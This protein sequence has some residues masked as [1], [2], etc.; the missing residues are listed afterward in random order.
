M[1]PRMCCARRVVPLSLVLLALASLATLSSP[2]PAHAQY[3][4][5]NKVHYKDFKWEIIKTQHFEV[6]FYPKERQAALDA[7]RMAERSYARLSKVLGYEMTRPIPLVLYASHTDFQQTNISSDLISEGTGGVTEFLKRRVFLPFTGSYSELEHVLTH[8]LVHAFQV[9]ILFGPSG[10]ILSNPV[11]FQPP[12]WFMEGMAEYLSIGETDVHTKMWLRDGALQGYLTP[13]PVLGQVYDIRVYRFGQ[14][15]F[16][17]IGETFGEEKIGE[18][19]KT[20]ARLNSVNSAF[21]SVLGMP[22]EELSDAWLEEVRKEYLP[23]IASFEKPSKFARRLTWQDDDLSNLNLVPALSP[24]GEHVCFISD[25]SMYSD[26][27]LADATTG[28]VQKRLVKGERTGNFESLRFFNTSISWSADGKFLAFPAKIGGE[29]AIY[30]LE[31]EN[32][33][34]RRRLTFGLDGIVSPSFSPDGSEIVF[35]GIDGGRSDLY[36]TDIDGKNLRQLTEDRYTDRDPQFSPDGRTIAF[37]TD[38]GVGTNFEELVFGDYGLALYEIASGAITMLPNQEGKNIAPQWSPDGGELLFVSDRTGI[39]NMY[40][41]DLRTGDVYKLTNILTGITGIIA[42]AAPISLS[43]DGSR[44]VFSA[45]DHSGWD[46]YSI[47]DPFSLKQEPVRREQVISPVVVEDEEIAPVASLAAAPLLTGSNGS[48]ES[49]MRADV[50]SAMFATAPP[51]STPATLPAASAGESAASTDSAAA[52]PALVLA[53][54]IAAPGSR[55]IDIANLYPEADRPTPA[56]TGEVV[57]SEFSLPDT[58]SFETSRYKIRFTQDYLAGGA[59]FASNVGFAGQTALAFSD[60]LGNHSIFVAANIYGSITD[61]EVLLAYANLQKRLNWRVALF[62]YH[63]DYYVF[64]SDITT[65][66]QSQIYRGGEASFSY[67]FSK[68]RRVEFGLEGVSVSSNLYG[69]FVYPGNDRPDPTFSENLLY[70]RPSLALVH[71][72]VLYGSTGPIHGSRSRYS[73]DQAIGDL[74]FTTGVADFRKYFNFRHRYTFAVRLLGG[75]SDGR[76]P[77]VFRLGG[78]YTFRGADYGA[79]PGTRIALSNLEFRFPLIDRLQLGFPPLDFRGIGGILFFDMASA[80]RGRDFRFFE[81]APNGHWRL[82]DVL[83]AYGFGARVNLGYFILR[84]DFAWRTDVHEN[85]DTIDFFTLS[86]DF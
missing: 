16:A 25:R 11:A 83:G 1:F 26:L 37:T 82:D 40:S 58:S 20:A 24:D 23:E 5:K 70:A 7:A 71:D 31:V 77:Q 64:T 45:F 29:D 72:N 84:Y 47:E 54:S 59:A 6:F 60:I 12:L 32:E 79:L 52:T 8:E 34:V 67:P 44:V 51:E 68:F 33:K 62:Q 19:L 66:F 36:I 63:N 14:S 49:T 69:E 9:E 10:N 13:L 17:F 42:S 3:F 48:H 18:V 50:A 15:V 80:W 56:Q 21:K 81:E 28:D 2:Q 41:I 57:S 39:S 86:A 53:D 61:S 35:V 73:I 43:R 74:Q 30:V 76:N 85:F 75:F 55:V 4:G 65:Q 46:L 22:L 38:R 27:Y 78:A